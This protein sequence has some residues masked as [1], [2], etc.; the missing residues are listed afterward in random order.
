V[1]VAF[2]HPVCVALVAGGPDYR[3]S[4]GLDELSDYEVRTASLMRV[5]TVAAL[6]AATQFGQVRLVEGHRVD[7]L[8]CVLVGTH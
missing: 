5:D 2:G 1:P 4:L 8:G 3:D 7:S 6:N